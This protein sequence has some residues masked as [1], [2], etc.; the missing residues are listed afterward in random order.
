M[1]KPIQDNDSLQEYDC[2]NPFDDDLISMHK[3]PTPDSYLMQKPTP[4]PVKS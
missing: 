1:L 4:P 2:N 3:I